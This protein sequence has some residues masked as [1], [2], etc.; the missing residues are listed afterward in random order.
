MTKQKTA[1]LDLGVLSLRYAF[2]HG[3]Y[4]KTHCA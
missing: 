3:T 4:S 1:R 2:H